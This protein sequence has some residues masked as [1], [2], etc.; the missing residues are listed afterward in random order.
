[1]LA[2]DVV[3]VDFG[4]PAGSEPGFIRPAVLVTA[5]MILGS[6]PRTVHVI[7]ITTNVERSLPTE[8]PVHATG[9]ERPSAAQ[10]HL[11]TVISTERIVNRDNGNIGGSALAQLRSLLADLFDLP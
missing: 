8:V 9:L 2:G 1:M 7:P 6:N 10:C 4:V 5:N 11:C 3:W